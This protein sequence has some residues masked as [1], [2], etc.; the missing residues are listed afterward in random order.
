MPSCGHDVSYS[1]LDGAIPLASIIRIRRSNTIM[2]DFI[3]YLISFFEISFYNISTNFI[4]SY[5]GKP[6]DKP[7]VKAG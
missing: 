3:S 2:Q 1:T 4:L 6:M 7:R 5:F